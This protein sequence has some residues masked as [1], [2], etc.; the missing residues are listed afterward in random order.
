[1]ANVAV[2]GV[3][4]EVV[5]NGVLLRREPDDP[6]FAAGETAMVEWG[7]LWFDDVAHGRI[8]NVSISGAQSAHGICLRR[9]EGTRISNSVTEGGQG[10]GLYLLHSRADLIGGNR[11]H[12]NAQAGIGL[13]SSHA[14]KIAENECWENQRSGIM[15]RRDLDSPDAPSEAKL[16]GNRCHGNAGA[17]LVLIS[18]HAS[19]IAENEGWDNQNSGIV[20]ERGHDSPDAPSEAKLRGN[21]CHGNAGAGL[22]LISSHASEIAENECWD[23]QRSG[24]VLARGHDSPDAPSEAKR[25]GNRCHGNAGAGLVLISAHASEI[26]DNECWENQ[27]SGI[28]LLRVL[29]SPDAP[30]EAKLRGNRF[31]GNAEVGISIESSNV[32]EMKANELW[33]NAKLGLQVGGG[34]R[35]PSCI[36]SCHGNRIFQERNAIVLLHGTEVPHD[37]ADN[38][39]WAS[40]PSTWLVPIEDGY[41][42]TTSLPIEFRGKPDTLSPTA[43]ILSEKGLSDPEALARFLDGPGCMHCLRDWWPAELPPDVAANLAETD[44]RY[45]CRSEKSRLRF[46]RESGGDGTAALWT[47][48]ERLASRLGQEDPD[49]AGLDACL[50]I[51]TADA[52]AID[53]LPGEV[54]AL[55]AAQAG[56]EVSCDLPAPVK[57]A[58]Q[59][60]RY[61]SVGVACSGPR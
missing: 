3:A 59:A 35:V 42:L 43:R 34:V 53:G 8:T 50:A 31:H 60:L 2:E 4:V 18:S 38:H 61:G 14:S 10:T 30:S 46:Q 16:R 32:A 11:C 49:A 1:M 33:G 20:L 21:R 5:A 24:I 37:L 45:L 39:V 25:R 28:L 55:R 51:V 52:A 47:E 29:D 58:I 57:R 27:R 12:G 7:V 17:G 13:A 15:L 26:A 19:E 36:G 40:G 23:N 22:V 48:L 6:P 44:E 54:A 56:Q 9:G 41:R